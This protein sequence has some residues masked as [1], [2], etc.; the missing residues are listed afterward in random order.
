MKSARAL[1][2]KSGSSKKASIKPKKAPSGKKAPVSFTK[3]AADKIK[4]LL[5]PTKAAKAEPKIKAVSSKDKAKL[6][7]LEESRKKAYA[8][9]L[10]T[11]MTLWKPKAESF[12]TGLE[13]FFEEFPP[14]EK[15]AEE[16]KKAIVEKILAQIRKQPLS[17]EVEQQLSERFSRD[18]I[19]KIGSILSMKPKSLLRLNILKGD[20]LG[21]ENSGIAEE[22]KIKRSKLSPW[23]FEIGKPEGIEQ[24]PAYQRGLFELQEEASQ[25]ISLLVNARAGQRILI[26]NGGTGDSA[27]AISAMM[28]NKGSVFVYDT[29]PKKLK[30]FKE[31]AERAGIDN[32]RILTDSQIAEVKGLDAVLIEAPSSALGLLAHN[33][34]LRL[35]FFK[36]ELPR[37]HKLQAALLREGGRKLKL[38]GYMIYSTY[39]LTKSENDE[40]VDHFLRSSHNSF[41]P[42][43][44]IPYIKEFVLP[45]AGN[46][47]G[48]T[49]DEKTLSSFNE[50][51][52]YFTLT[53][54]VH[55]TP[56]TFV[57]VIQ[58]TRI[59]S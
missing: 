2:A 40:Q 17:Q 23:A 52:P 24:H 39:T 8:S 44:V 4:T 28:K 31:R 57:A 59:S 29:D 25:I 48:F 35:R 47:F 42:V 12:E 46:F 15:D 32:F 26:L 10:E 21:F 36:E 27:L 43:P 16:A 34:D 54:D 13:K 19:H 37:I 20:L 53:P 58:R 1:K 6:L 56:G 18:R 51:E 5:K 30:L 7:K 33:P 38:G 14:Q 3:K 22:L 9:P 11:L 50:F 55:G 41:R 49:W 45:Y